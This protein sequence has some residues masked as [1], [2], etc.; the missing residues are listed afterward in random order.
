[1]KLNCEQ[2]EP[3]I[4]DLLGEEL[5]NVDRVR[6]EAHL[7][8]CDGCRREIAALARTNAVL[9]DVFTSPNEALPCKTTATA[10]NEAE[11][12]SMVS[13]AFAAQPERQ[14]KSAMFSMRMPTLL[15]YAAIVVISFGLGFLMRGGI[16][17]M[18]TNGVDEEPAM[19]K[20]DAADLS[21]PTGG[22]LR[23]DLE[24]RLTAAHRSA[25]Q[26]SEFTKSLLAILGSGG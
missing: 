25:P 11:S 16:A 9:R 24:A 22:N 1:M 15:R 13:A 6:L 7:V 10:N 3:L 26:A 18:P 14:S 4:A 21:V 23:A 20:G 2:L 17:P 5:D 12:T 19:A 8:D